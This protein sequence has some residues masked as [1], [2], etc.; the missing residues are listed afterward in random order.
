VIA[1][2]GVLAALAALAAALLCSSVTTAQPVGVATWN[3][4]WLMDRAAHARWVSTCASHGWPTSADGLAPE[5][6]RE[7]LALPYCNVHNG[8][9]WPPESCASDAEGWPQQARY[10]PRHP[11]RE[12]ADLVDWTHYEAKLASLRRSFLRLAA[13]GVQVV[14]L[15]EVHD[16]AAVRQILPPGWSVRT[17]RGLPGSPDVAQQVGVAWAP[18]IDP[19]GFTAYGKLAESG[20]PGRPLRPGF[21]FRLP[22]AGRPVEVLVVHLKAGC[23][24]RVIDDP[25]RGNDRPERLDA[26]A[27]DCAMLRNQVPALEGWIDARAGRDFVVI[28][29]F[30][31][32]IFQ[33]PVKDRPGRPTRLDG[34]SVASPNGPCELVRE[35][36]RYRARCPVRTGALFPELNDDDPPGAALWRAV[37]TDLK[38]GRIRAGGPGDCSIR[39][40]RPARKGDADLTHDGIDH[41]LLSESLKRRLSRG[42]LELRLLPYL[43]V[44][45]QP[46]RM[47]P[48][49]AFPSD[50]CPHWVVLG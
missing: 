23:R 20:V 42:A 22:I 35:G 37:F 25:L 11:C 28:G 2:R 15:Q 27:S 19:D 45:G 4:N 34:T 7:L 12:S 30:N 38:G 13:E 31:R 5:A 18:G 8:M 39:S 17:S 29:D 49:R 50:H 41:V 32:S 1:R 3:L 44:D 24:S 40:V 21:V 47:T 43:D 26:I 48:E 16:D 10:S 6:R 9:A 46:L 36:L 33:E 14:A